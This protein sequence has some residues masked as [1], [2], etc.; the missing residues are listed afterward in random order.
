MKLSPIE[1]LP[2]EL[3]Q[4]IFLQAEHN[5][6]LLKASDYIA[7]RLSS[8]YIYHSVCDYH[9]TSVHCKRAEQSAAQTYIFASKWMTWVFFQSWILKRFEPSQCLCDRTACFDPQWPPN[10]QDATNMVFS[11]SHLPRLAFVKGRL[12]KKLL[13]G[14]WTQDK[15]QFLRFLLWLTSMTVDWRDSEAR[16]VAMEGRKQAMLEQNLEA[17]ELFNHN[18]RLGK[19]A[20]LDTVCFAVLEAGC[21]RSIVYD[22]LR[23]AN[24][25]NTR[26]P[27]RHSAELY[28]WC[29]VRRAEGDPKGAWLWKKL[30]E[31]CV[32]D[33]KQNAETEKDRACGYVAKDQVLDPESGDYHGEGGDFLV[34]NELQWNKVHIH[35]GWLITTTTTTTQGPTNHS[36]THN[37]TWTNVTRT[38]GPP[39]YRGPTSAI[40]LHGSNSIA[41]WLA[42]PASRLRLARR[43]STR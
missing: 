14:P 37:L 22:T 1:R 43:P 26:G 18:R 10:F 32:H 39:M 2:I 35:R 9:L 15:V 6:A 42:P 3:L 27:C 24:M 8:P 34:V 38:P 28:A 33:C 5:I 40:Q 21:N 41:L 12:P 29:E 31:S 20:D 30:Q 36:T 7:A 19:A 17:V 11:R 16:Q 25:W 23:A 13:R 4:P